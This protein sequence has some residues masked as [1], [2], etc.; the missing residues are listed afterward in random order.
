[1]QSQFDLWKA[2]RARRSR[3]SRLQMRTAELFVKV[4]YEPSYDYKAERRKRGA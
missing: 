1:M 3:V 2:S 4:E